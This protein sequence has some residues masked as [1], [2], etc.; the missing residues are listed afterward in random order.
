ML[1]T[2]SNKITTANTLIPDLIEWGLSSWLNM[3]IYFPR[4]N[5]I[6]DYYY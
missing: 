2:I 5:C 3:D 6:I 1:T 4:Q